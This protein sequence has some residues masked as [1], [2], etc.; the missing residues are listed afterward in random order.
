[1]VVQDLQ[2]MRLQAK[3]M[4]LMQCTGMKRCFNL[5][6]LHEAAYDIDWKSHGMLLLVQQ[7]KT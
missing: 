3:M 5:A 2:A 6:A 7:V 4:S 1:M